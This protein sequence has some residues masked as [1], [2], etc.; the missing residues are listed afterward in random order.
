MFDRELAILS[1]EVSE[2]Y[3]LPSEYRAERG[4]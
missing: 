4:F 3:S 2:H 1:C